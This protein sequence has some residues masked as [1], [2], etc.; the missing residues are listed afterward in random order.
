MSDLVKMQKDGLVLEVHPD[1][2]AEHATQGFEFAPADATPTTLDEGPK[3]E[4]S[5]KKS[6]KS[7]E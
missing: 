1:A 2:I 3:E 4:G 7:K 6:K 5:E